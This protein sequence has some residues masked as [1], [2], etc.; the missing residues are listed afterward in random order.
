MQNGDASGAGGG[1]GGLGA[2]QERLTH[3]GRAL[4][5]DDEEG[6]GSGGFSDGG[7]S[8]GGSDDDEAR[9]AEARFVHD[10]HFGGG[11]VPAASGGD[12]GASLASAYRARAETGG[13]AAAGAGGGAEAGAA[14]GAPSKKRSHKEIME[15]VMAKSK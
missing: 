5:V 6:N 11:L 2:S 9:K 14:D 7:G 4:V 10:V 8:G 15:E 13:A 3:L 1:G 12:A